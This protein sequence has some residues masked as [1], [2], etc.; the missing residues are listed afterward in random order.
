MQRPNIEHDVLVGAFDVFST[1]N[2]ERVGLG[3]GAFVEKLRTSWGTISMQAPTPVTVGRFTDR[4]DG[5]PGR[6]R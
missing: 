5:H 3:A 4:I 1:H 2:C 6:E